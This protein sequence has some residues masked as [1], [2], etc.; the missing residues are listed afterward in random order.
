MAGG[1][2]PTRKDGEGGEVLSAM[3]AMARPLS[4]ILGNQF[5]EIIPPF[6]V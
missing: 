3:H 6:N 5:P 1:L 2:F 4:G